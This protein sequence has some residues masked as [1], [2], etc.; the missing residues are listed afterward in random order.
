MEKFN[1]EQDFHQKKKIEYEKLIQKGQVEKRDFENQKKK[2]LD[3]IEKIK[4]D[5]LS[6]IKTEKKALEQR[7][8]NL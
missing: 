6:K 4:Q 7:S 3:E 5:E 2:A 8:K 1:L